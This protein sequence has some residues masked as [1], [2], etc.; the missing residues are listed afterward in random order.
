M[1]HADVAVVGGGPAGA[2]AAIHLAR[3]GREVV[4]VDKA[5]FPRDKCCG[6]GLTVAALRRLDA[7]GFDPTR[8]ASWQAIDRVRIR[9]PDGREAVFP[10]PGGGTFA[11]AAKRSD[12]DSALVDLARDVGVTVLEGHPV[13]GVK[14]QDHTVELT[15]DH[16]ES[17]TAPYAV[18]ADGMWSPVRK[19]CGLSPTAYLGHWHATRQYFSNTGPAA[20]DL[21][22]WFE[23]SILPGYA[24]L[25]P[26]PDGAA[27]IG[28]GVRRLP[29]QPTGAA[30]REHWAGFLA[31]PHV[32]DVLGPHA[33][34]DGPLKVWPIPGHIGRSPLTAL[35]GRVI[36]VGDAARAADSMT[37]EGIA[38][39][40][41][42]AELAA[43]TIVRAGA[44]RP[45]AAARSYRRGISSG[46]AVDDWFARRL[47]RVLERSN[48][49]SAWMP[50][51]TASPRLRQQFTRWMFE[52]YPRAFFATPHRW[53][54]GMF[55]RSGA[56]P[57]GQSKTQK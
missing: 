12:L 37:G 55:R 56:F 39:A 57:T 47:S 1:P 35:D 32:A 46:L 20:S 14:A 36:F 43:Q 26:L 17:I 29:G 9:V 30:L 5:T 2:A 34:P 11:A 18:A 23:Q 51:A 21:W 44:K 33:T 48:H 31:Q 3:A 15:L 41:E 50:I 13:T 25:F 7:L 10:F 45:A 22:V 4:L 38:Q 16:G 52:D 49:P 27:N 54:R 28:L 6:D 24:W 8:V 53:K 42:T 19:L 40:L